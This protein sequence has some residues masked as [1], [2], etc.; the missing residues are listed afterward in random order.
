MRS[1]RA[2]L[3]WFL[4][5][6]IVL[7]AGIQGFVAYRTVLTEAD[8][9]FDHHMQQMALSLRAGLPP[10]ATVGGIGVGEENFEF[11]VQVWSLDGSRIFESAADARLPQRAVLGF[12]NV[13]ARGTTYRVFSLQ[14]GALV[15]QVA[16]DMRARRRMAGTLALN[17]V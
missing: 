4:L 2:R 8:D 10:S 16:Q 15:I 17:T 5:A 3:L 12:S 14:T 13:Q 1:L 7:A 11:I 6:A 9:I